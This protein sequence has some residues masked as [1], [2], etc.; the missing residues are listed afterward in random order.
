MAVVSIWDKVYQ[1]VG[2]DLVAPDGVDDDLGF[3]TLAVDALL[4]L[5][6]GLSFE[7][8][9]LHAEVTCCDAEF[10]YPVYEPRPTARFHQLRLATPPE[11]VDI[12]DIWN[13]L[14]VAQRERLDRAAILDWFGAILA[15]P[16]CARPDS[17]TGWTELIVE[18]LRARL[19]EPASALV[20]R[21]GTVLPVSYLNAVVDYPVERSGDS[22]WVAGPLKERSGTAPFALRIT[23][24]AGDLS[25]DLS[26]IWSA[27]MAEDETGAGPEVEAAMG[28][29]SAMGWETGP[30]R[31][32]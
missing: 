32:A 27:W 15:Q 10:R 20:E 9:A 13:D 12:P 29:L 21:D 2:A 14:H 7:P 16:E 24:E 22:H 30:A 26:L 31:R 5:G 11:N 8:L 6:D 19:P 18:V 17:G 28:R 3:A 25:L 23:N 4:A 1:H